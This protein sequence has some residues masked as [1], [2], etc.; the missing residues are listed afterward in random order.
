MKNNHDRNRVEKE[1]PQDR[2]I[3]EP[4]QR[5]EKTPGLMEEWWAYIEDLERQ[6][7][8]HQLLRDGYIEELSRYVHETT[9]Q[10]LTI[11]DLEAEVERLKLER[12]FYRRADRNKF[13][14]GMARAALADL[15][16]YALTPGMSREVDDIDK[17]ISELSNFIDLLTPEKWRGA[18]EEDKI[19]RDNE[20]GQ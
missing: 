14:F 3:V 16:G 5:P 11:R 15:D 18:L 8:G 17:W 10:A 13:R 2:P 4:P 6:L 19:K 7:S 20:G 9:Q 1:A 12:D